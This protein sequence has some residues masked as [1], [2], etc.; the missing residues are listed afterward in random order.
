MKNACV[1]G[2]ECVHSSRQLPGGGSLHVKR[3][4]WEGGVWD[5]TDQSEVLPPEGEKGGRRGGR[6]REGKEGSKKEME[7][8]DGVRDGSCSARAQKARLSAVH[9]SPPIPLPAR[10]FSHAKKIF[11]FLLM[12]F[13]SFILLPCPVCCLFALSHSVQQQ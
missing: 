3:Q 12:M 9:V 8:G 4:A 5:I 13:A 10:D 2:G 6:G 1:Q 11:F 7:G